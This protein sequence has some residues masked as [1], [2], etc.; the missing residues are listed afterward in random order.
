MAT[1]VRNIFVLCVMALSCISG[2]GQ[3]TSPARPKPVEPVE[4][5][6]SRDFY[7]YLENGKYVNKFF[8]FRLSAP[9]SYSFIGAAEAETKSRAGID[10]IKG[11]NA[12]TVD[13]FD[14]AAA[15]QAMLFG[16]TELPFGSP[17]NSIIEAGA[18]KQGKGVTAAM[19][20]GAS[21][22]LLAL[23]P[24]YKFDKALGNVLFN[25]RSF[26]GVAMNVEANGIKFK[27]EAYIIM[28]KGYSV[29]FTLTFFDDTGRRK[30]HDVLRSIEFTK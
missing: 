14:A 17:G 7:G 26:A 27:Q 25:R 5:V 12:A 30:M 29:Q 16:W 22:N 21:T 9:E 18:L 15:K 3:R 24:N 13:K 10:M 20:L 6:T 2:F 19:A 28:L 8:G 1:T 4:S 23:S 11:N